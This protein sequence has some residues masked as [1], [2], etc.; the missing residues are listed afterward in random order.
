MPLSDDRKFV[1]LSL[2]QTMLHRLLY[3]AEILHVRCYGPVNGY[4]HVSILLSC[5]VVIWQNSVRNTRQ[6]ASDGVIAF[7]KRTAD[8]RRIDRAIILFVPFKLILTRA[9]L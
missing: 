7:C 9:C 5:Q 4:K 3:E 2:L 6:G 8:R 1:T